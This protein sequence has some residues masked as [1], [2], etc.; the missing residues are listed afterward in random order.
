MVDVAAAPHRSS[1][2]LPFSSHLLGTLRPTATA[3]TV[4][5]EQ[6]QLDG[7]QPTG[8][9][10]ACDAYHKALAV[11]DAC[12]APPVDA[13]CVRALFRRK[14]QE[15]D[16]TAVQFIQELS[17]LA[18]T[19]SFRTAAT[20]M[21]QDQILQGS[22]DFNLVQSFIKM[23]EAFTVQKA[24]EHAK[25]ETRIARTMQQLTTQVN[26]VKR[27]KHGLRG[28]GPR[29]PSPVED[30]ALQ[31]H[32]SCPTPSSLQPSVC[33]RCSSSRRWVNFPGCR[34]RRRTC[35]SCGKQGH[36][37][38]MCRS[39]GDSASAPDGEEGQGRTMT[40]AITVLS[41][42]GAVNG[43]QLMRVPVLINGIQIKFLI[44]T[45]AFVSLLSIQDYHKHFSQVK[46]LKSHFTIHNHSEQVIGNLGL[47]SVCAIPREVYAGE[48]FVSEKGTSL[49]GLN[50]ISALQL[51]II[52]ETLTCTAVQPDPRRV[53]ESAH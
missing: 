12:F 44:D 19:C 27:R 53:Q 29:Q 18:D 30:L 26:T 14:V 33:F 7:V 43:V 48:V 1:Q 38:K 42:Q 47:P 35:K 24:L 37:S 22:R 50:A 46:L 3:F 31:G 6:T 15:P 52:G 41:M 4:A 45:G 11:L 23:E 21:M 40:N 32:A 8:D 36:F 39:S 20:T 5:N 34:L 9:G 25:K 51:V 16:E 17:R 13:V 28:V 49:L 2:Q 10:A